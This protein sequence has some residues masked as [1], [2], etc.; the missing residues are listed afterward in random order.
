MEVARR[1]HRHALPIALVIVSL[2]LVTA[3]SIRAYRDSSPVGAERVV[4]S[5]VSPTFHAKSSSGVA[6]QS[7]S[8]DAPNSIGSASLAGKTFENK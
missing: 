6:A 1:K 3:I 5:L 2:L 4:R 8:T 7:H